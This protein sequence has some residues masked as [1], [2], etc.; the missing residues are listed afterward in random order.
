M[1]LELVYFVMYVAEDNAG[2]QDVSSSR[3][4]AEDSFGLLIVIDMVFFELAYLV[5]LENV[6]CSRMMV[7]DSYWL[8]IVIDMVFLELA[9]LVM[10][11]AE[12]NASLENR[13][14]FKNDG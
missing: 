3:M 7:E 5:I 1:F 6:P 2:F 9:Y 4:M 12:D 8:L 10:Y 11:V 14:V 13:S